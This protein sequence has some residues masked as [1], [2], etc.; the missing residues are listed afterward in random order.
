MEKVIVNVG[1][2]PNGYSANIDIL[3]GWILGTSG[4]FE[5]F[6]LELAKS[7]AIFL[8]WAKKDGDVYPSV[9][10]KEYEFEYKFDIES[11]LCCYN[12]IISR[13]GL[14]RIT[15]INERQL[16]HYICGRSQPRKEQQTKIINALHQL[17]KELLSV[18]V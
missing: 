6:K 9:F 13:S 15:G 18:S 14:A 7:I 4:N 17:G 3:P 5:N 10:D 11:L 8:K 1:K 2:T 12:G 16:G